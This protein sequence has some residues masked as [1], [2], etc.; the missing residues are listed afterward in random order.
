MSIHTESECDTRNVWL[1]EFGENIGGKSKDCLALKTPGNLIRQEFNT[2][3]DSSVEERAYKEKAYEAT[4]TMIVFGRLA[5]NGKRD[6]VE[7]RRFHTC[8]EIE[9]TNLSI[10]D[11][12][13]R[14][15]ISER[16]MKRELEDWRDK[17]KDYINGGFMF[18]LSKIPRAD[19]L[20]ILNEGGVYAVLPRNNP[21]PY[22]PYAVYEIHKLPVAPGG[23][24]LLAGLREA[25]LLTDLKNA[26]MEN[27]INKKSSEAR[28]T[29]SKRALDEA[30]RVEQEHIEEQFAE[31]V[32]KDFGP[33]G[34]L[35][36]RMQSL[37]A[38]SE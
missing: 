6:R 3:N 28:L 20:R 17:V 30:V 36:Q 23:N 9:F 34:W 33:P 18:N 15:E 22:E 4:R 5:R 25:R 35:E 16:Q 26:L 11:G 1:F 2:V 10:N 12:A 14:C 31:A 38:K 37:L 13:D 27:V 24:G 8:L 32:V 29:R 7:E 19:L 21:A